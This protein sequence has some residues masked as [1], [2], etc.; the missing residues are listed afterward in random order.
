MIWGPFLLALAL[1]LLVS[2][3]LYFA[4]L[5]PQVEPEE[6]SATPAS[7]GD[8]KESAPEQAA[9]EDPEPTPPSESA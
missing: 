2:A 9:T 3:G 8:P 4:Y 7:A 5:W 1:G 6:P